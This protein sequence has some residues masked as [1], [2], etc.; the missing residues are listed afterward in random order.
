MLAGAEDV[1]LAAGADAAEVAGGD[2]VALPADEA[3][4]GDELDG[5]VAGVDDAE[6][7][8]DP[9]AAGVDGADDADDSDALGD[10]VPAAVVELGG[11]DE[12]VDGLGGAVDEGDG[13]ATALVTGAAAELT[14]CVTPEAALVT[15]PRVP[16]GPDAEALDAA[17]R[18]SAKVTIPVAVVQNGLNL[19]LGIRRRTTRA[20]R[21]QSK[22]GLSSPL[23]G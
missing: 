11:A 9:D 14:V 8:V 20:I 19:S 3:G 15:P 7:E 23:L 12:D 10:G 2:D 18:H 13:G 16:G 22:L 21:K 6:P 5:G 1:V 17:R 4:A